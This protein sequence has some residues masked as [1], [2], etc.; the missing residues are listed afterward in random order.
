MAFSDI[1][2][3]LFASKANQFSARDPIATGTPTPPTAMQV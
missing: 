1:S 3:I 2:Q